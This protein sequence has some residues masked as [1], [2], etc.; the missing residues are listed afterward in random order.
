MSERESGD[1]PLSEREQN[2]FVVGIGASAGG[3]R[4]LEELFEHMSVD[5]GAAF[6]VIQHLSPDFKSLMKELLERRTRMAI[7][8]VTEGMELE[9]NSVY[10]IPPGK[11][12]VLDNQ[13]LHLLEQEERNRHGLNFPIDIFLESLA[14]T[15]AERSIGVILSGTGSD[16]TN[17]LRAI[18]EAGGFAMVQ[19]PETAEF[20]GMPR[21]AIATGVVDRVLSPPELAQ[22]INQ[23]VRSPQVPVKTN[24]EPTVFLK[25]PD[26]QRIATILATHE[27]TDFS[28]YK[29]S[30]LSRRIQ[31]RYLISGCNDIDEFIRLLETSAE[32]RAILRHDLLISVTQFFRDRLA[33]DYLETEVIPQLIAK[34]DPQEELRCWVTAC[35]T[36]E[37]AYSLAMLLDEAVTNSE[38]PVR[39][40]IFATDI[41]KA[42]LEKATQGIYPQTI[43]NNISPERLERYFVRKD[44]SL[45]VIRKL[46][47]K[48]LFAP[49]DLT[50]DAGFTRMN[51][52]SCRN[53]LIYLQSDL[54]QVVL[55]N[56]HFSLAYK[57][58][59]FLGEAETL[60]QIEP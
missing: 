60:G 48:L 20:D 29:T 53:V 28:H 8:R 58:I 54:Q 40:K 4:A 11:N 52:I 2:F 55:R 9:P 21:T 31:R 59:L 51:L 10:L 42:A 12:L 24:Q 43:I 15:Y 22:L 6:V 41:D 57:G 13:K 7:Y 38:K 45:Q 3:L 46:R 35:A 18:N 26:L 39:F 33:W 47:E 49:H 5:S 32:E 19:E 23:L 16:G 36:G 44:N 50:K 1:H 25:S 34:A 14:K 27:H 17:G 56:L 30:T 37:E